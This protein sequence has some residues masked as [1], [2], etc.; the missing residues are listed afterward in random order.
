VAVKPI[1]FA[2]T[3]DDWRTKNYPLVEWLEWHAGELG[4]S[5]YLLYVGKANEEVNEV[6]RDVNARVL[7]TSEKSPSGVDYRAF[8]KQLALSKTPNGLKVMLDIDEFLLI[9]NL[10]NEYIPEPGKANYLLLYSPTTDLR[11]VW[12]VADWLDKWRARIESGGRKRGLDI[13]LKDVVPLPAPQRMPRVF[14]NQAKI[15]G[16]GGAVDLPI[17]GFKKPVPALHISWRCDWVEFTRKSWLWVLGMERVRE[18]DI[19][20]YLP[21]K[22]VEYP[23]PSRLREILRDYMKRCKD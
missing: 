19:P 8:Y 17:D 4:L 15:V 18:K 21:V 11:H 1:I 16:D 6:A 9:G 7:T 14:W 5:T 10:G 20:K 22:K 13:S 12:G 3:L 23:I 2:F